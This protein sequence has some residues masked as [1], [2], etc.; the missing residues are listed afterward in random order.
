ML[1]AGFPAHNF[2]HGPYLHEDTEQYNEQT[3]HNTELIKPNFLSSNNNKQPLYYELNE[4]W[5]PEQWLLRGKKL[6]CFHLTGH[7]H[8]NSMVNCVIESLFW[9]SAHKKGVLMFILY[10]LQQL[11]SKTVN[12]WRKSGLLPFS[13]LWPSP[14]TSSN[15]SKTTKT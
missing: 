3:C 13:V 8:F 4:Y 10:N 15:S 11:Q 6:Y 14:S 5:L 9:P 12:E 2:W 1:R 7:R